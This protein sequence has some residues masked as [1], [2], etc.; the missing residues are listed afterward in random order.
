MYNGEDTGNNRKIA[1][2]CLKFWELL[3]NS[4]ATFSLENVNLLSNPNVNPKNGIAYI[5]KCNYHLQQLQ[6]FTIPFTIYLQQAKFN[7][8][9]S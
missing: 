6:P 2:N 9:N 5:K 8:L 4:F 7:L 3:S 1:Q